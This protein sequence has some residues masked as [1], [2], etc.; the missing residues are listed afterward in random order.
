MLHDRIIGFE[1]R[2]FI[3][4]DQILLQEEIENLRVAIFESINNSELLVNIYQSEFGKIHVYT[5]Y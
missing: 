4:I 2:Y 1:C 5:N 3:D